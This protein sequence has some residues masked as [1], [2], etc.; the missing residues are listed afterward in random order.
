LLVSER[1]VYIHIFFIS[2]R[3][4]EIM[5]GNKK[6][7][8]AQSAMEYL[9][10]YGWAILIIAVVLGALFSLGVFS[11]SSLLGTSC[12]ASPGYLCSNPSLLTSGLLTFTFGQNT[13]S[14]I[15]DVELA[16]GATSTT[17]GLPANAYAWSTIGTTGTA[18][19]QVIPIG[20]TVG[21]N[22]PV[23]GT[24]AASY[25]NSLSLSSGQTVQVVG[26]PCFGATTTQ[27]ATANVPAAIGT[28]FSGYLWLNYTTTQA[29]PGAGN[30]WYTVKAATVT[31]KV[32]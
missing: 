2:Y 20:A 9:M 17:G 7:F 19:T 14:T 26:L 25:G 18:G 24:W 23:G 11:G 10:T 27:I 5:L 31:L 8:K 21:S 1:N 16:C 13:G 22:V 28:S 12:V 3:L 4:G 6:T 29:A 32:V 30:S 15:Y